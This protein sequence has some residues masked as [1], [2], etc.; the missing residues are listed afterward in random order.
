M[1]QAG[2]EPADDRAKN[3][4]GGNDHRAVAACFLGKNFGDKRDAAAEFARKAEAGDEP[5]DGVSLDGMDKAVGDVGDGIKQNRAEKQ[6]DAAKAVAENAEG[7][8]A[9]QAFRPSEN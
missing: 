3:A 8:S 2:D 4:D 7:D 9:E 6:N 1:N 5:P